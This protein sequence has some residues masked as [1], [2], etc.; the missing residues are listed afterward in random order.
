MLVTG[1]HANAADAGAESCAEPRIVDTHMTARGQSFTAH[2]LL[3]A[4][5]GRLW[6]AGT[7]YVGVLDPAG[8]VAGLALES[9]SAVFDMT[10]TPDGAIWL[11]TYAHHAVVRI[12]PDLTATE[13]PVIDEYTR[14]SAITVGPDGNLWITTYHEQRHRF[15]VARMGL[16]GSVTLQRQIPAF[17]P[18]IVAGPDGNLWM[19]ALDL[20]R[21]WILR[22]SPSGALKRY[23]LE[24]HP[25]LEDD[26]GSIAVG[27]DENLWFTQT[28]RTSGRIGRIT[29]DGN[30]TWFEDGISAQP[31]AITVGPD[32]NLWFS[33]DPPG[34]GRITPR[35]T[36]T[37]FRRGILGNSS[38][39]SIATGPTGGCTSSMATGLK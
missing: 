25:Y 2:D 36:V 23:K 17:A 32:G 12:S 34:V 27:P 33:E 13:F 15:G 1:L 3:T 22:L 11:A 5:D 30:I 21:S 16:D 4:T 7:G 31:R 6:A 20:R 10:Q 8:T 26:T 39:S 28:G 29:T 19:R 24:D 18:D 9:A 35:G 37:E 38:P 14:P